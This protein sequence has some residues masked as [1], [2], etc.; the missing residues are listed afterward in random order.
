MKIPRIPHYRRKR[1]EKNLISILIACLFIVI[2]IIIILFNTGH[3]L[4]IPPEDVA[5]MR[6]PYRAAIR[7]KTM[8]ENYG[9]NFPEI[10]AVF[11]CDNKFSAELMRSVSDS[12]ITNTYVLNYKSKKA[13]I[14]AKD[15]A[16]YT[17]LLETICSEIVYFPVAGEYNEYMYGDNFGNEYFSGQSNH[18]GIDIIERENCIGR[19]NIISA[20]NGVIETAGTN[21]SEGS[22]VGV[23]SA[24]GN[25][26]YYSCLGS[27]APNIAEGNEIVAGDLLGSMGI[28]GTSEPKNG[29]PV[30][31]HFGIKVNSKLFKHETWV[32]PY[33]FL[34]LAENENLLVT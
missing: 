17:K 10:F 22:F 32:N 20:A 1:Y 8:A 34:R 6:V 14:G 30:R 18:T 31:L 19:L 16:P 9:I 15:I 28:A 2:L 12:E 13:S 29:Y 26:Y 27:L 21:D 4:K 11:A 23:R 33:I 5:A 7:M 25:L 3:K 24:S